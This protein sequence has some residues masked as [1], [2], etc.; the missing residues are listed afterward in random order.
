M[1]EPENAA[2]TA[3][4]PGA[5]SALFEPRFRTLAELFAHAVTTYAERR[6]FGTLQADGWTWATYRDLDELVARC[7]A[8]L[9]VLGVGRG[10]RVATICD[11][12][13][14]W[15]VT[16]HAA[17]QRRAIFVPMYEAQVDDEWRHILADSGAKVCFVANPSV[18]QRVRRLR[19][20]LLDLQHIV[21]LEGSAAAPSEFSTILERGREREIK[22]REPEPKDV[23]TIIY[24]SGT[25]GEPKGVCLTHQNLAANASALMETRDYG[26]E[27]RSMAFLPWAHVFG[28]HVELNVMMGVGG[29]V[30]ICQNTDQLFR[31]LPHVRPTVLYAVPRIWNRIYHLI[32]REL[33][34][35]SERGR[36][37]L[38]DWE[39]LHRRQRQGE[40]LSLGERMHMQLAE[41]LVVSKLRGH[42]GGKLRWAFSG[43]AALP[44]EVAEFM[45][46]LGVT[47]HEGYGL[48]ESSGSSTSNPSGAVRFGSVGKPLPG[49]R[50]EIDR[51][52]VTTE[53]PR[54]G[55][56]V[57]HGHGVMQGYHNQP[58]ATAAVL[59]SE[60]GLR[61][62]DVGYLDDDGYLYITGRLKELYKLDSGRYVAPIPLEDKLKLSPFISQCMLYGA[63][64]P[65]NVALVVVDVPALWAHYG[66]THTS[67]QDMLADPRTRRLYEEEILKYS[68]DFRAFELVRNFW[69]ELE[70][71]AQENGMLTPTQKLRRRKV[72]E[73][74]EARL[75]SLY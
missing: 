24:T 32:Q 74:Y 1:S 20:D 43:A 8:G 31:E 42:F 66:G 72:L 35:E 17:Y 56:I 29:A 36:H 69:L 4:A 68:R 53:E 2:E 34:V 30:A 14:E 55:E 60:R 7:R 18:A 71:F 46:A 12:R 49:V 59:T 19:E 51:S 63:G 5:G 61:T 16:A 70:P 23:A 3:P 27:P 40:T 11:N 38:D 58:D 67:V 37:L 44:V 25:T 52:A 45:D 13:L 50:I 26:E 62:G 6:A 21:C 41:T 48:T 9:A 28:A 54:E 10:D 65:Y 64:Q 22:A 33:A 47:I 75:K 57:I 15:V 39:R 73:R